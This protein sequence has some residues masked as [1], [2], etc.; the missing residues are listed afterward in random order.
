M[1]EWLLSLDDPRLRESEKREFLDSI[2]ARKSTREFGYDWALS[3]VDELL[4]SSDGQFFAA[5]LPQALGR[6]CSVA[7]ANRI[8]RDFTDKLAGT[9]GALELYRAIERVRNCGLLDDMM[10]SQIDAEF[11]KLR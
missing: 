4:A 2:M 6:F 8:A 5:R 11:T 9:P 7:W 1:A 10:G 3:H